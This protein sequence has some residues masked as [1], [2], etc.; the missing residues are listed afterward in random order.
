MAADQG[1]DRAR[2]YIKEMLD[3]PVGETSDDEYYQ[4]GNKYYHGTGVQKDYRKAVVNFQKAAA[5]KQFVLHPVDAKTKTLVRNPKPGKGNAEAQFMLG[6]MY[7]KGIGVTKNDGAA[8]EWYRKAAMQRHAG[9]RRALEEI[10][11]NTKP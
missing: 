4:L 7:G 8:Y 6:N 5:P 11:A 3:E 1:H 10:K 9:A 2:H